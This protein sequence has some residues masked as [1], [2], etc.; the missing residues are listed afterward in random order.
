MLA[1]VALA[2]RTERIP[3][4]GY[5]TYIHR[6]SANGEK[7]C[8]ERVQGCLASWSAKAASNYCWFDALAR[9]WGHRWERC[10][11]LLSH[12]LTQDCSARSQTIQPSPAPSITPVSL[13]APRFRERI[14]PAG[15]PQKDPSHQ[16]A[17]GAT[18]AHAWRHPSM[19]DLPAIMGP[20]GSRNTSLRSPLPERGTDAWGVLGTVW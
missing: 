5:S 3:E 16:S 12:A 8:D 4:P 7:G 6:R 14:S 18:E 15:Q 19:S 9:A 17:D 20:C 11:T 13:Q 1:L 10:T 2:G